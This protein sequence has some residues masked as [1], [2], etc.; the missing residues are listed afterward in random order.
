MK[1]IVCISCFIG[2]KKHFSPTA[3]LLR[4]TKLNA[5]KLG[6]ICSQLSMTVP[7]RK[8]LS[9]KFW[10]FP[11]IVAFSRINLLHRIITKN[12]LQIF[13][14]LYKRSQ[15][16]LFL[17]SIPCHCSPFLLFLCHFDGRRD[18]LLIERSRL[19]CFVFIP[20]RLNALSFL[21]FES[22]TDVI[23]YPIVT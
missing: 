20:E 11:C 19:E 2:R 14:N 10:S 4:G 22:W 23:P 9:T 12:T 17:Q 18:I 7:S 5:F 13:Y 6:M 16:V 3:V 8:K 1:M 21:S 15:N